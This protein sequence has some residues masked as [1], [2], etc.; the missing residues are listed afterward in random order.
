[1][2]GKV[3]HKAV[4]VICLAIIAWLILNWTSLMLGTV[5]YY[6]NM[7]PNLRTDWIELLGPKIAYI[8]RLNVEI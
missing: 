4:F 1:M 7:G 6:A 2:N 3:R 5:N 8:I